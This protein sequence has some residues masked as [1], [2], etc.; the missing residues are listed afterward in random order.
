MAPWEPDTES[1]KQREDERGP[2]S[3]A[4]E[5]RHLRYFLMVSEELHFRRAAQRLHMSQ[6]PLS[7]AI[8]QLEDQLGVLLLERTSRS[9]Q[10]T[11]AGRAFAEEAR[12][13]LAG[14]DLAVAGA[15]RAGDPG[16]SVRV[17][18]SPHLPIELLLRFVDGLRACN[19]TRRVKVSHALAVEQA[20]RLHCGELDF[21]IFPSVSAHASLQTEPLFPGEELVAFLALEHPLVAKEVL[22]PDDLAEETLVAI[23]RAANP[24]LLDWLAES[25]ARAG[26]RF[27]AEH[28]ADSAEV[29]DLILAVAAGTGV[30]VLPPS[31]ASVCQS[32]SL[33]ACRPL[34]PRLVMPDS[35]VAWRAD[36]PEQL[37]P[38]VAAVR[39][40]ARTLYAAPATT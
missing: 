3:P 1:S 14:F 25:R 8:R 32:G 6:P 23:P 5:L 10:L 27:C 26:Y 33:V 40:L 15:R 2:C 22:C 21:A 37:R 36:E 4:I 19:P 7:F 12:K 31:L 24:V 39:G 17:G 9:V 20:R 11:E 16:A 30:A 34:E 28:E 38:V 29:R 13:V 35:I 18:C